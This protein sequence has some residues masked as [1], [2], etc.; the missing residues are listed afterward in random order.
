H[1]NPG[2]NL[3]IFKGT[4]HVPAYFVNIQGRE[5]EAHPA[6]IIMGNKSPPNHPKQSR[7]KPQE[8]LLRLPKLS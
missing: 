4:G 3:I 7:P 2:T 5:S 8:C 1:T 6:I